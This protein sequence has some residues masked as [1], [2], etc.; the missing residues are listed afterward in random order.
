MPISGPDRIRLRD[1]EVVVFHPKTGAKVHFKEDGSIAIESPSDVKVI[2]GGDLTAT[3]SGSASIAATSI[4]LDGNAEVTGDATLGGD[5]N[6]DGSGIGFYGAAP[7]AKP[8]V[9]GADGNIPALQSLL[10]HLETMGL[11]VDN[12]V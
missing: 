12:S 11:L 4:T 9:T 1:G 10:G 5:L 2:A 7:I 3:V 8:T 6:H